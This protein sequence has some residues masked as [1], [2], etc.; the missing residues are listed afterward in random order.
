MEVGIAL[1]EASTES[2]KFILKPEAYGEIEIGDIVKIKINKKDAYAIVTK[3]ITKQDIIRNKSYDFVEYISNKLKIGEK[4]VIAIAQFLGILE[5][6][7]IKAVNSPPLPGTKVIL[8]DKEEVKL[9]YKIDKP[10][11]KI[12]HLKGKLSEIEP[13]IDLKEIVIKHLAVF[14]MT[15]SGKSHTIAALLKEIEKVGIPIIIFDIHRDYIPTFKNPLILVFDK[16][17]SKIVKEIYYNSGQ[18]G[19]PEVRVIK[20]KPKDVD[21]EIFAE[22]LGINPNMIKLYFLLKKIYENKIEFIKQIEELLNDYKFISK[23]EKYF[24]DRKDLEATKIRLETRLERIKD[25]KIF[26]KNAKDIGEISIKD[27]FE[28]EENLIECEGEIIGNAANNIIIVD[29][30]PLSLEEQRI[31][32]D[33]FLK[34][35]FEIWKKK[36]ISGEILPIIIVIEEA[37]RFCSK[38][39]RLA[40]MISTIAREGRKFGIGLWI[41]SQIPS[42]IVEEVISQINTFIFLRIVNPKDLRFIKES[43]PYVTQEYLESLTSLDKGEALI[44]G[45]GVKKPVILK[46]KSE[47]IK[48][49]GSEYEI[50][51]KI[52][53]LYE[54]AQS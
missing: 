36:K 19:E 11:I 37:H 4:S 2:F 52:N 13:D 34:K 23:M 24:Q 1:D 25:W 29:L 22:T 51:K 7:K 28:F 18:S 14:G 20:L 27:I 26:P 47:G 5:N 10:S 49:G 44:V 12:G 9:L 48:I 17:E 33:I 40:K 31:V 15:G 32:I 54:E 41:V 16:E 53:K 43:N 30:Y 6:G 8:P 46:V 3:I 35:I 21:F 45:I 38:D 39:T 50:E 42:K